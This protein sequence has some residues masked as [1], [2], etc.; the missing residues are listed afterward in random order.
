[1][2]A[3]SFADHY[4]QGRQFYRSQ[5]EVEQ[6]HI[7][8]AF[9]F[10]LSKCERVDIRER[11]VAHLRNV[12][13]ELAA[14][15]ADGLGLDLPSASKPAAE[16]IDLEPSPALSI[17]RNGPDSFAGRKLGILV[18]DGVPAKVLRSVKRAAASAGATVELVAPKISGVTDSDGTHHP[19]DQ[20]VDGGPS[21][22][23]DAVAV[24]VSEDGAELLG[25]HAPALDFV[26]DAH[27]HCK[28]V[29]HTPEALALYSAAGLADELDDGY[30]ELDGTRNAA[31]AFVERCAQV[32]HWD[33]EQNL[34][35]L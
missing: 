1:V 24:L 5:T 21:V 11:M 19:A 12:D 4:S 6:G 2:R 29:A 28:F 15:V 7:V 27:A 20:K 22:L 23:Y 30:V 34:N 32:R 10:E 9:V 13:D 31:T 3:E 18:A 33:R 14:G 25:A 17:L 35:P 16:P 8:D 26:R